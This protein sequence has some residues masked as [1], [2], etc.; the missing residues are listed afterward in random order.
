MN[1][2]ATPALF[3]FIIGVFI[4]QILLLVLT[5]QLG[6]L[7]VTG[8]LQGYTGKGI[9]LFQNISSMHILLFGIFDLAGGIGF[10]VLVN[11]RPGGFFQTKG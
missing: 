11:G 1:G 5:S 3:Q 4:T 7:D 8:V 9:E 10:S 2:D 6:L